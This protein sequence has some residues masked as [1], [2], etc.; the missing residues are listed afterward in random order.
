MWAM[1]G[2]SILKEDMMGF[3]SDVNFE[4]HNA[5]INKEDLVLFYDWDEVDAR[6]NS[7][8]CFAL[9]DKD[10]IVCECEDSICVIKELPAVYSAKQYDLEAVLE[11]WSKVL[12]EG[13][14][15]THITN[16]D[17]THEI[18]MVL[19]GRVIEVDM[20][21]IPTIVYDVEVP[22]ALK[23]ALAQAEKKFW[24][25]PEKYF[26]SKGEIKNDDCD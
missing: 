19:P 8:S 5:K 26:A 10:E 23:S 24:D 1:H 21:C 16:E 2:K 14:I 4:A 22:E 25:D 3:Y 12:K 13:Y 15:H 18:Y 6:I 9:P 7:S 11:L 20:Y 17:G